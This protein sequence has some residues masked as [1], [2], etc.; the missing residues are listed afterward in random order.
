MSSN[1]HPDALSPSRI[2]ELEGAGYTVYMAYDGDPA[3]YAWM[4]TKSG[5]SQ[6]EHKKVQPLRRTK[7]QAWADCDAYASLDMPTSPQPDWEDET[8]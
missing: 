2:K 7:A 6:T 4:N 8:K 3:L 5:A 1:K